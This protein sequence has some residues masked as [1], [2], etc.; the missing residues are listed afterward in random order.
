[1]ETNFAKL[2]VNAPEKTKHMLEAVQRDEVTIEENNKECAYWLMNCFKDFKPMNVE[3]EPFGYN[4]L[5]DVYKMAV[6]DDKKKLAA[7]SMCENNPKLM[8]HKEHRAKA[9]CYNRG[10]LEVL[11][12]LRGYLPIADIESRKKYDEK[13]FDFKISVNKYCGERA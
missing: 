1:M 6:S 13:I 10:K 7:K 3:T 5:R 12:K 8:Q 4:E 9:I 11:N 2:I